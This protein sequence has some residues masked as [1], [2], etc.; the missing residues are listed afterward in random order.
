MPAETPK[1]CMADFTAALIRR[2]MPGA[3]ALLAEDA[4]LFYSNGTAIRG[5][6][7]F[8]AVMSASWAV[9]TDYSYSTL[10]S[11]WIAEG[12]TAAAVIYSFNWSGVVRGEAVSGA[13]RGTRV[14]R[15]ADS[16]WVIAHEHLS[17]GAW[18]A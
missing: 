7:A 11:A 9:V 3:L 14:F 15:K 6:E 16:G 10:D 2:D 13:G 17:T 18:S 8:S 1:A 12:E 5:S 4:V